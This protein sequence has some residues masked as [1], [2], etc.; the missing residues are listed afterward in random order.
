MAI[1]HDASS[2]SAISTNVASFSW[3]HAGTASAKGAIVFVLSISATAKDTSVTYGG[4]GMTLIGSG[5]DTDTEPGFVRCYYLDAVATGSQT[6]LVNRTNDATQVQGVA[7]TVT[8]ASATQTYTAGEVTQGGSSQNTG[9]DTSG[10]GTAASGEVAVDDGS[11][12]TNSLRYAA[13]Y[14]GAATPIAAGAN[15]TSLQTEDYTAFGW[16]FVRETTAG[17]GSRNVGVTT[18]TTDDRASV[19][20]AVRETPAVVPSDVPY[21]GGGYYPVGG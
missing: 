21:V 2:K 17:Q 11:P 1:G 16:S 6:V 20:I 19:H 18:G 10:T 14:T 5:V 7:A 13:Y 12:G 15:S 8:A 4:T 3:T 9:A